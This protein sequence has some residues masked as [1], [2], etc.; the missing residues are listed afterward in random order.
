MVHKSLGKSCVLA[1]SSLAGVPGSNLSVYCC[2]SACF[3]LFCF[4]GNY[5]I[6]SALLEPP[7]GQW[8]ETSL[9]LS[10]PG[11]GNHCPR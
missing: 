10:L 8:E 1:P 11:L 4:C 2:D 7:H 3:L 6:G 5:R 9:S